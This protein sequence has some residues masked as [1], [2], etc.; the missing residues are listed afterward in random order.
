MNATFMHPPAIAPARAHTSGTIVHS[1][2]RL[3]YNT[4]AQPIGIER[5][6][7]V[8]ADLARGLPAFNVDQ[9]FGSQPTIFEDYDHVVTAY[10]RDSGRAVSLIAARWLGNADLRFLY[11]WTA[12]VADD[13]RNTGVFRR[14]LAWFF[15]RV[16][17]SEGDQAVPP[18][19]VTKTYNPVVY[20]V[21]SMFAATGSAVDLYPRIPA[22]SQS[23]EMIDLARRVAHAISP[24]L[25]LIE[26]TGV[27]LGG[28]AMVAPDFF[29]LMEQSKDRHV[30]AHFE[31][32]L[33]RAD[34]ILCI[35][36]VP[37]VD[38]AAMLETLVCAHPQGTPRTQH[39]QPSRH[40]HAEPAGFA[41]DRSPFK[42]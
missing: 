35:A 11:L 31:R 42:A 10:A 20:K 14:S 23:P 25:Q 13:Y 5:G 36:R 34:Q 30:N 38:R 39:R 19:I 32:H 2:Y 6:A 22:A 8:A 29:P 40:T 16:A 28:Q 41:C 37:D 4:R 12:M 27:V 21:F 24:K 1:R 18:L 9:Y 26:Q 17:A 33:S 15:E 7:Q 3:E